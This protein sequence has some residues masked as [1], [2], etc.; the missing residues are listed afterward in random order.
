M[1]KMVVFL[2][3]FSCHWFVWLGSTWTN[4]SW[5]NKFL[6]RFLWVR[7]W[8]LGT[9][10]LNCLFSHLWQKHLD[11]FNLDLC[12]VHESE[13]TRPRNCWF[14]RGLWWWWIILGFQTCLGLFY[15]GRFNWSQMGNQ[16]DL[17]KSIFSFRPGSPWMNSYC[18][19][20]F[21]TK[22]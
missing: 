16:V 22:F 20:P 5:D 7:T 14:G 4:H 21:M 19:L 18:L 11:L 17:Q 12:G 1:F 10:G 8:S 3:C 15:L 2:G 9:N 6:L 13:P